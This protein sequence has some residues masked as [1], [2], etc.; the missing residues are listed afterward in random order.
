LKRDQ[1][2]LAARNS[3]RDGDKETAKTYLLISKVQYTTA[4]TFF[5][6]SLYFQV[7]DTDTMVDLKNARGSK[8]KFFLNVFSRVQRSHKLFR[9]SEFWIHSL[10]VIINYWIHALYCNWQNISEL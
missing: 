3:N 8:F 7:S 2:K 6:Q 9:I 10:S 1:Y 5:W 4:C